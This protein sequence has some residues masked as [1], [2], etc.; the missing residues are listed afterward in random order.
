MG[1]GTG[2]GA[3]AGTGAGVGDGTIERSRRTTQSWSANRV[4]CQDSGC[5][6]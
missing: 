6:P 2:A 3:G 1:A 5:F 4:N